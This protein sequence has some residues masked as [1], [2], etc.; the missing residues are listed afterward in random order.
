MFQAVVTPRAKSRRRPERADLRVG[1]GLG[2]QE[3]GAETR[4]RL[5]AVARRLFGELGY[6]ATTTER[7]L[8]AAGVTRGAL[9]HHFGDKADLMR[10]VVDEAY[11]DLN[12]RVIAVGAAARDRWAGVVAGCDAFLRLVDDPALVRIVFVDG[13]AALGAAAWDEID[14]RHG[15]ASL[16]IALEEAMAVGA[17]AEQPAEPLAALLNGAINGAMF[18]VLRQRDPR[19]ALTQARSSLRRLLAALHTA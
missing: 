13:P 5:V 14:H 16:R 17:L 10:A 18:W 6:A 8:E 2:K 9:Y 7:I 1:R 19:R 12:E 3:Q 4:A 11:G 15:L